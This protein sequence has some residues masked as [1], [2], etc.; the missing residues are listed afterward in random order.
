MDHLKNPIA[1]IKTKYNDGNDYSERPI[2]IFLRT[3]DL[4][5][6]EFVEEHTYPNLQMLR[7]S[8][9]K[10]KDS[11]LPKTEEETHNFK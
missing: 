3:T 11:T 5:R 8:T 6:T 4:P 1:L 10:R 7:K 9:F 2:N